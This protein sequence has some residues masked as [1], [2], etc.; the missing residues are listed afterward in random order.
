[1]SVG[2]IGRMIVRS[3]SATTGVPTLGTEWWRQ[4]PPPLAALS[5]WRFL[6]P[7]RWAG[8]VPGGELRLVDE[9][10]NV[11][12]T[13]S[14]SNAREFWIAPVETVTE[15]EEGFERV[16]QGSQIL[17]VW[18]L[19]LPLGALWTGR[20]TLRVGLARPITAKRKG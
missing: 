12:I 10:Q 16:Y 5:R 2:R 6:Q 14:A 13:L 7:L 9:W 18:P 19:E 8:A 11:S 20:F 4:I 1:M 15:S 3:S 17:P